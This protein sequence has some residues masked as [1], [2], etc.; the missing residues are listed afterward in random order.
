MKILSF[1][2]GIKNLAYCILNVTPEGICIERWNVI[3]LGEQQNRCGYLTD[4]HTTKCNCI[5]TYYKNDDFF[6]KKHAKELQFLIPTKELS[7][8]NI[9]KL[10]KNELVCLGK[11][12][13]IEGKTKK[14]IL[15]KFRD[16]IDCRV[17]CEKKT[18]NTSKLNMVDIGISLKNKLDSISLVDID[19][20]LI[21]NQIG[22]LAIKMKSLQGMLTQYFIMKN[23]TSIHYISASNKL[24]PYIEKKTTYKE[25]KKLAIETTHKLVNKHDEKWLNYFLSH[26]KKDDLADSFLQ[27]MWF[28]KTVD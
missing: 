4:H 27:A 22:P 6:C 28:C 2:V 3:N 12:Y 7:M 24:K 10:S 9:N 13:N 23:I 11:K 14:I 15:E 21:E 17:L 25:R 19:K 18:K 8:T 16:F 20:V 26:K 5:T 1:D